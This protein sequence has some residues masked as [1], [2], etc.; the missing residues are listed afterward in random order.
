MHHFPRISRRRSIY[1][2]N[3]KS[4]QG[5]KQSCVARNFKRK[6]WVEK[7]IAHDVE[8]K[9]MNNGLYHYFEMKKRFSTVLLLSSTSAQFCYS[10]HQCSLRDENSRKKV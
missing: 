10:I 8:A 4:C 5:Q 1:I 3:S 2:Y 9:K 6:R 7:L